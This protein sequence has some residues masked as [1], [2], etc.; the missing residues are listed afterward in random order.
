MWAMAWISENKWNKSGIDAVPKM[1]GGNEIYE[2]EKQ[3]KNHNLPSFDFEWQ[4]PQ[5]HT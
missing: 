5:G 1:D 4:I 2:R 3:P